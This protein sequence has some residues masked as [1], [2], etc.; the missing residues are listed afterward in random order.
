MK[1]EEVS[2]RDDIVVWLP[3][4]NWNSAITRIS[5]TTQ[6]AMFLALPKGNPPNT[7]GPPSGGQ[8]SRLK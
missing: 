2:E 7:P 3:E 4:N 1:S 8:A 5:S 6:K